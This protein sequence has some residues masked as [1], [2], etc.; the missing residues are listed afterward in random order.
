MILNKQNQRHLALEPLF[1]HGGIRQVAVIQQGFHRKGPVSPRGKQGNL[2]GTSR[3]L[4]QN[5]NP[6][7][8]LTWSP[9]WAIHAQAKIGGKGDRGFS[10]WF[11]FAAD[12][13]GVPSK[14]DTP[15]WLNQACTF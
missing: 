12:K 2:G 11:P 6:D 9:L 4:Q 8:R 15:I 10:S 5:P 3:A 7:S 1:S 13:H 14:Q